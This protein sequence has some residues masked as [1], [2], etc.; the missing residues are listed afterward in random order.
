LYN[1]DIDT[2]TCRV[3][4]GKG[5]LSFIDGSGVLYHG[6]AK[7]SASIT[8]PAVDRFTLDIDF[9]RVD[10]KPLFS[11]IGWD[12]GIPA[13]TVNGTLHHAGSEFDP[14]GNFDYVSSAAGSDILGRVKTLTGNYN[15][16]GHMLALSDVT[17]STGK[18]AA[19]AGGTVDIS[20]RTLDLTGVLRTSDVNDL[21]SPY[22]E[23]LRG[24][25]EFRGK[26][27]G[28]FDDPALSGRT[29]ITDATI[30]SYKAGTITAD[31]DYR[32]NL[33][34]VKELTAGRQP[35][36]LTLAGSIAF[37]EARTLFD[38]A[39][40]NWAL[41]SVMKN[42]DA[43]EFVKI[44]YPEFSGSGRFNA[45]ATLEGTEKLP[46]IRAAVSFEKAMIYNVPVDSALFTFR[47]AS[48]R[49]ELAGI[50]AR[51]GDSAIHG[52]F[53]IYP[54]DTFSYKASSDRMRLSDI[55][56]RPLDGEVIARVTSEGKG[57]IENPSI[58]FEARMTEGTLRGKSVGTGV[59]SATLRNREFTA[60]A[61]LINDRITVSARGRTDGIMPWEASADFQN[62]R[63]DFL[64]TS[65]LKD[66]PE[67]LILNLNGHVSLSGSRDH[68]TGS[69]A[70]KHVVLSMYGYSF[71]NEDEINVG[72]RD[73][74]ISLGRIAMRS[75][76]T[77]LRTTGSLNVGTSYNV[78]IEGNSALSPFK[79]LSSKL[80]VLKGD[81]DFVV[82][83]SGEWEKPRINGGITLA[84][85]SIGLKEYPAQRITDLKGY[86]YMD[87]D[88]VVL[89]NLTGK[90][91]G[92]D[93]DFSG[94]LY[95]KKFTFSRFYVEAKMK[96]VTSSISNEFS[97]NFD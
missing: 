46:D 53:I 87:N 92:G 6:R 54:D 96:N 60:K 23:D 28:T 71:T 13:G 82:G 30:K 63:Y 35:E 81:A 2:V 65:A 97:V 80:G 43:G 22:F 91:G 10:S 52:E 77:L 84:N 66:V 68:I 42:I 40:P 73:R 31:L 50:T 44:F 62:G 90:I 47:Y 29:V 38:L 25:A 34:Q 57:T 88:R 61:R 64:I 93:L 21:S 9:D 19:T 26:I 59:L 8:L 18:T 1:V 79:S 24:P 15:L 83:I 3:T 95:L 17:M 39:K 67:D 89:Q 86:L 33:L 14:Q 7:A 85:G 5:I 56:Q 27:A 45:T 78:T 41:R 12:P 70:V 49:I 48:S 32:K 74:E 75:G 11:L 94:I 37:R 4:Y 58:T 55:I 76:N 16:K 36:T 20:S 69:A 72:L 51:R